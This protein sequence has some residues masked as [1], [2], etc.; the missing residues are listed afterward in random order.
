MILPSAASDLAL[1]EA[2]ARAGGAL[3]R[4]AF[5]RKLDVAWKES[6]FAA[7]KSPVTEV[8]LAID[9]LLKE[10]LTGAQPDYGWLSEE[11]PDTPARLAHRRAFI[12]D[13]LDGTR[14]F[15][16]GEPH[17]CIS[18]GIVEDGAAIL[19]CVYN[20]IRD[21]MFVGGR[22]VTA[23]LNG[24][25]IRVSQRT[26]LTQAR[27]IGRRRFYEDARWPMPWPA[28]DLGWRNSI[29]YRLSLIAAGEFDGAVMLGFKHEWDTA[30]G[31][32]ILEAAGGRVTDMFGAP[33]RFNQPDPQAPGCIAT[34]G[35]LH[36][37]L[38]ERIAHL[39]HPREWAQGRPTP[40]KE[41]G[42]P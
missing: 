27:L 5:G 35:P 13:P 28:L 19:G 24:A 38:L 7:D 3:A 26:E 40:P 2:A 4:E 22:G 39:P 41:A 14:S 17:F 6:P 12:V 23:A 33:L 15:L 29:A 16:D 31:A 32:A 21:E 25:P 30:G 9:A 42:Q 36:P 8:D 11:T 10:R 18:I 37:A 34:G 20:P 1:I